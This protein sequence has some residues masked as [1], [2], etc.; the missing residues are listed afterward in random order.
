MGRVL[1]QDPSTIKR[2]DTYDIFGMI[3]KIGG[4]EKYS[5]NKSASLRRAFYGVQRCFV[6]KEDNA[7]PSVDRA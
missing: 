1:R 2:S 6:R 4:W 3:M 7:P 5:G